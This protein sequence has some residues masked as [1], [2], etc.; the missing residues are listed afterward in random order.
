MVTCA[1]WHLPEKYLWFGPRRCNGFEQDGQTV[2]CIFHP[3]QR[4]A[5]ALAKKDGKCVVCN[6]Q[7]M[8]DA[9]ASGQRRG[10]LIHHL[11]RIRDVH[12]AAFNKAMRRVPAEWRMNIATKICGEDWELP[13][14]SPE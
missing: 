13:P 6:Q 12:A 2:E 1:L 8:A 9:C 3:T 14:A 7:L 11:K 10:C 4:G 5:K